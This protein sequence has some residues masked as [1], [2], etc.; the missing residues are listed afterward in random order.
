MNRKTMGNSLAAGISALY[1]DDGLW[2]VFMSYAQYRLKLVE[3]IL[4][5]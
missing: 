3:N 2:R 4:T 5:K 1:D